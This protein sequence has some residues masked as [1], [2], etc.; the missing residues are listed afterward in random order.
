MGNQELYGHRVA[1]Y[2]KHYEAAGIASEKILEICDLIPAMKN[3]IDW[4][5]G[6]TN[7]N[8]RDY[9]QVVFK[10]GSKF[11]VVAVKESSRGGRRHSG[12][13]D[14]V[15]LV[16]GDK[17]S[18]VIVPM[19][20]VSRRT[21]NGEVDPNDKMNKSQIFITSAGFK[22]HFSY[23]KQIQLLVWQLIKPG[24]AIVMGGTWRIPVKM[25]LLDPGFVNDLKADG[26]FDETTFAREYESIWQGSA[27]ESFYN[28]DVFD[29]SRVLKQPEFI[30]SGRG[31]QDA[32]YILG[33]DVGRSGWQTVITVIKVNP[34]KNGV[35]VKSIVNM[36]VIESE[37]FGVQ[38]NEIK[39]QY[40]NYLPKYVVV[41]ANGLGI[42]LVDFLVMPSEDSKT[43][44]SFSAFDVANDEKGLY[45]KIDNHGD[46][47]GKVLWLIKADA[48]LNFEGYTTLLQQMGSGKIR[49]LHN[50]RDAK[51]SFDDNKSFQALTSGQK[52]D[53]IRPFVL[54]TA[55]K[56]EMMNLA[57]KDTNSTRFSL[58]R[59]N[60]ALGKDKVSSLMYGLYVIKQIED[61][62]RNRK[63]S[64][65]SNFAF[66]N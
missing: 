1:N 34:Q 48:E 25:G 53:Q 30:R 60:R 23:Q 4:G 43:G 3:E 13:I 19:M 16:D 56:N 9:I 27:T 61:K 45:K 51:A 66:F 18:Q 50:E 15:V 12:L 39:R 65:L 20:N 38:A 5:K 29:R 59:I 11:D 22:S 8:G 21:P 2:D 62:N 6:K 17:F 37:H 44:E 31:N 47:Y 58:E 40:L 57:Q 32:Y 24:T 46:S 49:L 7:L 42:G 28:S 33:I 35:G 63:H 26:T 10:N 36:I 14:E 54:T 55:L 64:S 41:D 52:A